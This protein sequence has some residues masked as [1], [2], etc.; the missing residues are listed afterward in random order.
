MALNQPA[1]ALSTLLRLLAAGSGQAFRPVRS[2]TAWPTRESARGI[3]CRS[4]GER[5]TVV[6]IFN[7]RQR[8]QIIRLARAS[9]TGFSRRQAGDAGLIPLTGFTLAPK[10]GAH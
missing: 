3:A 9:G 8:R 7:T 10:T 4:L 1:S 2:G 5:L 6:H